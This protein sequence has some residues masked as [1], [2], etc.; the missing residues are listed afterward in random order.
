MLFSRFCDVTVGE[1]AGE[2]AEGVSGQGT[3]EDA[4]DDVTEVVLSDEDT[5]DCYHCRPEEHPC[6]V[7]FQPFRHLEVRTLGAATSEAVS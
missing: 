3:D 7:G 5:A 4:D 2:V 1:V 6:T